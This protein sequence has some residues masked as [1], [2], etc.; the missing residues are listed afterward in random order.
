[1]GPYDQR[2]ESAHEGEPNYQQ[3][4][5]KQI[6]LS[7]SNVGPGSS[8][9][10]RVLKLKCFAHEPALTSLHRKIDLLWHDATAQPFPLRRGARTTD[11]TFAALLLQACRGSPL[12]PRAPNSAA[13]FDKDVPRAWSIPDHAARSGG[14]WFLARSR[15][16]RRARF[17]DSESLKTLAMSGSRNTTLVPA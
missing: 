7:A 4:D 8:P 13:K 11:R 16:R 1:M 17:T 10:F 12:Q 9:G 5:H 2:R 6:L 3:Q 14:N 15:R